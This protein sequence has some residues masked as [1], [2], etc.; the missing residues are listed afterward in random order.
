VSLRAKTCGWD[1]FSIPITFHGITPVIT[2]DLIT[3][4]GEVTLAQVRIEA[5]TIAAILDRTTHEDDQLFSCL[6]AS[7]TK[8]GRNTVNLT[9][10]DLKT[11]YGDVRRRGNA[12]QHHRGVQLRNQRNH[13][14]A[15][16]L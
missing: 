1:V 8:E 9:K 7:L 12:Q 3:E 5:E 13:G 4:Y 15:T 6:M 16:I 11:G 2:K 14:E 10:T